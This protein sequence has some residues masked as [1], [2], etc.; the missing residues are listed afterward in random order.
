MAEWSK[1]ED[2]RFSGIS[3]WVRIFIIPS[4]SILKIVIKKFTR[5]L[6]SLIKNFIIFIKFNF[7]KKSIKKSRA[8]IFLINKQF[9]Y[10]NGMYSFKNNLIVF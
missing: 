9:K 8:L 5:Y 2:S 10:Q 6:L 1:A 7:S 3:S 4:Q